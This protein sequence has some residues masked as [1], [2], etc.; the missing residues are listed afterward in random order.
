MTSLHVSSKACVVAMVTT[1]GRQ[2]S[3]AAVSLELSV[4][5]HPHALMQ[6][7]GTG[8]LYRQRWWNPWAAKPPRRPAIAGEMYG[9]AVHPTGALKHREVARS[10]LLRQWPSLMESGT[11]NT[12]PAL[13][14]T[15]CC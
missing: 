12:C 6:V 15:Q 10:A 14:H 8:Q 3:H 11:E 13:S 5:L 7:T 9:G 4:L 2:F 1:S